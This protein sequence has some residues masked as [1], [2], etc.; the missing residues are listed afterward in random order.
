MDNFNKAK[1]HILANYQDW[2]RASKYD[3]IIKAFSKFTPEQTLEMLKTDDGVWDEPI[4]FGI[5]WRHP[6]KFLELYDTLKKEQKVN[7]LESEKGPSIRSILIQALTFTW[8]R[9]NDIKNLSI[10]FN[11]LE[12]EELLEMLISNE[13]G[14][15]HTMSVGNRLVQEAGRFFIELYSKLEDQQKV[16]LLT[17]PNG[18]NQHCISHLITGRP[19]TE[20]DGKSYCGGDIEDW[21]TKKLKPNARPVE[22]LDELISDLPVKLQKQVIFCSHISI[23]NLVYQAYGDGVRNLR[24]ELLE[25]AIGEEEFSNLE[26]TDTEIIRKRPDGTTVSYDK[27]DF[28][29][30]RDF[31]EYCTQ[32]IA[33][34]ALF[35]ICP[36]ICDEEIT[37]NPFDESKQ[38]HLTTVILETFDEFGINYLDVLDFSREW[39]KPGRGAEI[40]VILDKYF[41]DEWHI[42]PIGTEEN[43]AET[44]LTVGNKTYLVT[45]LNS[46]EELY[47][48]GNEYGNCIG[49]S[50]KYGEACSAGKAHA[51]DVR[52]ITGLELPLTQQ[53]FEDAKHST[54][55]FE[56]P[57]KVEHENHSKAKKNGNLKDVLTKLTKD[58]IVK[59]VKNETP[60]GS[61][62][63]EDKTRTAAERITK[64]STNIERLRTFIKDFIIDISIEQD[65]S[66]HPIHGNK[67]VSIL[68]GFGEIEHHTDYHTSRP[69]EPK[70]SFGAKSPKKEKHVRRAEY[71]AKKPDGS[72]QSLDARVD[73]VI[74]V[75]QEKILG[76]LKT[77]YNYLDTQTIIEPKAFTPVNRAQEIKPESKTLEQG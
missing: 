21:E 66:V 33:C 39:H 42:L 18:Q 10:V 57:N 19:R 29:N 16:T 37:E 45:V 36:E 74:S 77:N 13:Y 20:I 30:T 25:M 17:N 6:S 65:R 69:A 4:G 72:E 64:M 71:I 63:G 40:G 62:S 47:Q 38:G 58:S 56:L 11:N 50:S 26:F 48:H 43:I 75:L 15:E 59:A 44:T 9:N 31:L 8:G 46:T 12:S 76:Y 49:K 27:Y 35:N 14:L 2:I 70:S 28:Q 51:Y 23:P 32:H 24:K 1:E 55:F 60:L 61:I 34:Q 53:Q 3:S 67:K 22:Q 68:S 41:Q 52:D 7:L 54:Y 5:S 73:Q